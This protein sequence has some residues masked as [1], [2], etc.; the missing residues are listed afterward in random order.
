[1]LVKEKRDCL[2]NCLKKPNLNPSLET[3]QRKPFLSLSNIITNSGE[4]MSINNSCNIVLLET[5]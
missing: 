5:Q 4:L 3:L 1:M 2:T